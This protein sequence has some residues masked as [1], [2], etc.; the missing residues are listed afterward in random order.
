MNSTRRSHKSTN[1][2]NTPPGGMQ[3]DIVSL[4]NQAIMSHRHGKLTEAESLYRQV[5]ARNAAHFDATHMLGLIQYQKNQ[6]GDALAL[7]E[8]AVTMRPREF[9]PYAN[10]GLVLHRL[11]RLEEAHASF[12]KAIGI[13]SRFHEA[14]N[15]RG[16]LL[17]D[18]HE[19]AAALT[20]FNKALSIQPN[21]VQALNNR[22][23]AL[24][25]L[26]DREAALACYDAAL[27]LF[28][29]Y[30]EAH[31]NRGIVLEEMQRAGEAL[32]S[33]EQALKLHPAYREAMAKRIAV[34]CLLDRHEEALKACQQHLQSQPNSAEMLNDLG[35]VLLALKRPGEALEHY[36]RALAIRPDYP[37]AHNNKGNALQALDRWDEALVSHDKAIALDPSCVTAHISRG[38]ALAAL[39]KIES[40]LE[41]YEHAL[42]TDPGNGDAHWN[43]AI[44]LLLHGR[45]AKGW[46]EY[47]YR[48]A[49]T[50]AP[51]RHRATA[52]EWRGAE[53]L[54][55]KTILL[56]AEQGLGDTLQF[57]RFVKNV[58]AMGARI[59][60]EVPAAL[61]QVLQSFASTA[62]IFTFDER[63]PAHD[64]QCSLMSLPFALKLH[65]ERNFVSPPYL[66]APSDRTAHWQ[67]TLASLATP[68][69]GIAW[70]GN[71]KHHNDTRRSINLAT[72]SALFQ[73]H[74][75][76]FI[77]LQKDISDAE[78]ANLENAPRFTDLSAQLDDLSETAAVIANLDAV[79][80][81]DTVIAH[82]AGAL[83]KPVWI[84]LPFTPDYRWLLNRRDTPWYASARLFRQAAPGN[85]ETVV[86]EIH[87]ALATVHYT[88]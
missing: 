81:V 10:L 85:W 13:H 74:S 75:G 70:R 83:G 80:T 31:H 19:Y 5:L 1:G 55:G 88:R 67:T 17:L 4:M 49:R 50:G 77:G 32:Q 71:P 6:L 20:D 15:N 41:E 11:G 57:V 78:R 65:D 60:L 3:G 36:E 38:N 66:A 82:L 46:Q 24:R 9:G 58:Q 51:P 56:Y 35:N 34:L 30:A 54:Q 43:K 25:K 18:L 44:V 12:T 86:A 26:G 79:A 63:L 84:L 14:Y 8:A 7:L 47:E 16:I 64:Y 61:K 45:F 27:K 59:L 76:Q 39:Q 40:A 22:G 73:G 42:Q 87:A 2:S 37:S 28:P 29:G 68:R 62:E 23:N 72:F 53:S 52:P 33:F 69:I 21:F 48:W